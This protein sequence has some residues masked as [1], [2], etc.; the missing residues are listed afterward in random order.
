MST[1]GQINPTE[2]LR[3]MSTGVIT[4]AVMSSVASM[5]IHTIGGMVPYVTAAHATY[6]GGKEKPAG[7]QSAEEE[8]AYLNTQIRN[9]SFRLENQRTAV[10]GTR[11]HKAKL[12]REYHLIVEPSV[13]EMKRYPRLRLTDHYLRKAEEGLDK[14]EV[15]M[16]LLQKRRKDLQVRLGLRVDEGEST[17]RMY[18]TTKKFV[19][20]PAREF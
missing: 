9:L 8:L 20:P 12:M 11:S 10:V 1:A 4:L 2:V 13:V 16:L 3:T 5:G 17:R 19:P 18:P 14:M 15:R 6:T 7:S